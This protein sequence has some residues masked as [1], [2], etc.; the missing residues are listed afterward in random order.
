MKIGFATGAWDSEVVRDPR[1]R[2]IIE[3]INTAGPAA[4]RVRLAR[5][6]L[7]DGNDVTRTMLF[8]IFLREQMDTRWGVE[9][10]FVPVLGAM[11]VQAI[12]ILHGEGGPGG[13]YHM[14]AMELLSCAPKPRDIDLLLKHLRRAGPSGVRPAALSSLAR[15]TKGLW[16]AQIDDLLAW[17]EGAVLD[18][19]LDGNELHDLA[20]AL[21][22]CPDPRAADLLERAV[23]ARPASDAAACFAMGLVYRDPTRWRPLGEQVAAAMPT[24]TAAGIMLRAALDEAM[25][26]RALP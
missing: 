22:D 9:N 21:S 25:D 24:P 3:T 5:K 23:A 1:W 15:I 12:H 2:R 16:P 6:V 4:E 18:P 8:E 17:A 14:T 7:R 11:R 13:R 20:I 10:P 26:E 19:T